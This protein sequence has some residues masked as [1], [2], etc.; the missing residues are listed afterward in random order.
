MFPLTWSAIHPL[1]GAS[2]SVLEILA[3]E[4][5]ASSPL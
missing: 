5:F 3:V 4:M 2:F 1:F